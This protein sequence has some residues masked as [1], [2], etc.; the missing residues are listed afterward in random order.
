MVILL[1]L[2]M[3]GLILV[4]IVLL[5]SGRGPIWRARL[6]VGDHKRLLELEHGNISFQAD[7]RRSRSLHAHFFASLGV[8]AAPGEFCDGRPKR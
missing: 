3:C 2:F 6:A 8:P 1:S 5:Q 7:H 4:L